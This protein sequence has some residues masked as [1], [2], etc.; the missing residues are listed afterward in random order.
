MTSATFIKFRVNNAEQFK[1]SVTEPSPNTNLYLV[2]GKVNAWENDYSPDGANSSVSTEYEI[3]SNMIAGKKILGNDISHVIPR[4]NWTAN[5]SYIS[6][7]HRNPELYQYNT[8]FYV[9]TSD[10][11]VYKCLANNNGANSTVE[12]TA[13]NPGTPTETSDGYLWKY[14]Y[15]V[16]DSELLRFATSNFIPV[17]TLPADE[18]SL[19]WDVQEAATE[20]AIYSIV[21]SNTGSGYTNSSNILVTINGDGASAEATATINTTSQTVTSI[22]LTDYGQNYT[23]ATVTITGGGG[24]GAQAVAMISPPGGHG[25]NP[26][27]E[28]GGSALMLN[29]VIRNSEGGLLPVTND[30]RQIA[31]IKDPLIKSGEAISTNIV[32]LQAQTITTTGSGDYQQDEIVYQGGSVSTATFTARVVSWDSS[33]GIAVVINTIGTPTTQSLIGANSTTNR[34][35]SSIKLNELKP[36]TGQILYVSNIEPIIRSSDQAEDYRI[37][38]KF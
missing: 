8:P 21:V 6:Y 9:L 31:L 26:I 2:Y 30:I 34:F 19:Q 14:M 1:E 36:Y 27:Y 18:G 4:F 37:V 25:S 5:T 33:N 24:T 22:V 15:T 32:V 35:V 17:K 7:D 29:P 20:G 10:Y 12:P 13:I 23:Q 16:S 28:L 38:L 3:W 11:N